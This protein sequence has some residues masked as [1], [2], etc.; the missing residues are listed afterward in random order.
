MTIMSQNKI[1]V[2]NLSYKTTQDDLAELFSQYGEVTEAKLIADYDGRSKGFAFITFDSDDSA[3]ASLAANGVEY[4]GRTL[5]VNLA[6][7]KAEKGGDRG[8]RGGD[9]GGRGGFG[10]SD[11]GDRRW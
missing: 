4:M 11:R 1:Y 10:G 3:Q 7:D 2:G 6:R 9:R 5:K 8:S